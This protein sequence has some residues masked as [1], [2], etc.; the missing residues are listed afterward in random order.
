MAEPLNTGLSAQQVL[1]AFDRALN[2]YTD[3]EID[4]LLSEKQDNI[5]DLS[6]IRSGAAEGATAV[7]QTVFETDQ[8]RQDALEAE[9][10]AALIQQVDGGAKN[11]VKLCF[12]ST[13]SSS[14]FPATTNNND[15]TITVNGSRVGNATILVQDLITAQTTSVKTRYTLPAGNYVIAPTGN[16][17]IGLQ[18]YKH[19]GTNLVSLGNAK[20]EAL[21]FTYSDTDKVQYPYIC[22]RLFCEG[23]VTINNFTF[24]PMVCSAADY[25][26][27]PA[28]VPYRPSWQEMYD[29][30]KAL[31]NGS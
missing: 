8:A 24:M 3:A 23:N 13:S 17:N 27:S 21:T 18:V 10:R 11:F 28:F 22:I 19:N 30:I 31:Q 2:D 12:S 15:G 6:E 26:I 29:M 1:T 4:A 9:D 5:T 14:S 20:T 7:Q 25:A 16:S